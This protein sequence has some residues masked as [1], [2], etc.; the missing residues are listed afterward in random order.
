MTLDVQ[1]VRNAV[2]TAIRGAGERSQSVAHG[3]GG[4]GTLSGMK[5]IA[6]GAGAAALAPVAIKGA[7][8]LA[9]G[10]GPDLKSPGEALGGATSR[11]GDRVTSSVNEK[12]KDQ[13]EARA[14]PG[15]C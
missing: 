2:A 9:K 8:K 6:A 13:I 1:E 7:V 12:I 15:G 3:G 4:N 14:G 11:L 5:G 10:L